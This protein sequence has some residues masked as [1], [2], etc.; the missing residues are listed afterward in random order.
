M[1]VIIGR[2]PLHDE[3]TA[4]FNIPPGMS[5]IFSWGD[6]IYNPTGGKITRELHAHEEVHAGRQGVHDA[7]VMIW[8]RRYMAEPL[9]RYRE[10]LP[11]HIAEYHAYCKRHGSGRTQFLDKVAWRL[12]S[13][14]YGSIV[15]YATARDAI[16]MGRGE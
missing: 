5:V 12:S 7:D 3:I 13:P 9:F 2:C 15:T 4:F 8:W 16:I 1:R 14:L 11:A 10:E 6:A